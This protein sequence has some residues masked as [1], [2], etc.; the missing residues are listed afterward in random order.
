V[1]ESAIYLETIRSIIYTSSNKG[2][3]TKGESIFICPT[4]RGRLAY[5]HKLFIGC[6]ES[7]LSTLEGALGLTL[8]SQYADF[9]RFSC[10]AVLFDN[11]LTILGLKQNP[12]RSLQL[13]DQAP[14][15]IIE[16]LKLLRQQG[17][18]KWPLD[19]IPVG[20]LSGAETNFLIELSPT[21]ETRVNS[22][23]GVSR[24]FR[25]FLECLASLV[26]LLNEHIEETGLRDQSGR[27][28]EI[29]VWRYLQHDL[30]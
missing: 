9:L 30:E 5:L 6:S 28:L 17:I 23:R 1:L 12:G 8:P 24:K 26:I 10:G 15:S 3:V 13:E 29:D 25:G 2:I 11:V 20:S 7:S 19:W 4:S 18:L 16:E 27:T 22:P 21:G 14:G